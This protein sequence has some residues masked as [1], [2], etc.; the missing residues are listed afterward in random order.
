M[1]TIQAL[2]LTLFAVGTLAKCQ[3]GYECCSSCDVIYTDKD[4]NWGVEN[5]QWCGIDEE[6]CSKKS[7]AT[8]WSAAL[9]YPCCTTTTEVR[10][11]DSDGKWGFENDSW[12]GIIENNAVE[13]TCGDNCC[14]STCEVLYQDDDGDWGVEEGQWCLISKK[15]CSG[16]T[17][18]SSSSAA[19]DTTTTQAPKPTSQGITKTTLK[20]GAVLESGLFSTLPPSHTQPPYPHAENTGLASCGA[21]WT[22]VDN[23]C[24][25]MYCKDK[26]T[27]ENCDDCGG[28]A[29][30]N[31]CVSVDPSLCKSGV[32]PEVHD[33]R[34]QPWKYSRSTHFGL[35]YGG[36]CGFG[37]YG[38]CTTKYNETGDLCIKFCNNYPDLCKDP[39]NISLRGNFCAPNGNYYTQ[40]W[41][42]LP[43]DYDNYLSC[44]EC[45]EVEMTQPDGSSY[46][47]ESRPSDNILLQ[48]VDSCPCTANAKWCCGS[49]THHCNEID[50]KYG[51]PIPEGSWHV[52]LSDI[53]MSRLQTNDPYGTMVDG[54]IPIRYKRVPC[55]VKGNIHIWLR[56]GA[57][58][59]YFAL[60]VVNVAN[61]GSLVA[62]EVQ[63]ADGEW[64]PLVRDPNYSTTRPQERYGS[65]TVKQGTGPFTVPMNM[66]F[67]DSA[68]NTL[69]AQGA[70]KDWGDPKH[71]MYDFYYIDTGVQFPMPE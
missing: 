24:V 35:T 11:E 42:S 27:S 6:K 26:L 7:E 57:G 14:K 55:P 67:T 20:N 45:Y 19:T 44:G 38:L 23:V 25:A 50:F 16:S 22:M 28:V 64:V 36:A 15:V 31:G 52:D 29:R 13:D 48:V 63:Q 71:P 56:P 41:S 70:I 2:G 53:A 9:G 3:A 59:W 43:G 39:D 51:C 1:K 32:W 33:A 47:K 17:G 21:K 40:F 10:Y 18:G 66:R 69:T 4:G 8:C 46:P 54:V 34:D 65:W 68:F 62:V 30:K 58:Q 37:L 61:M 60:T 49:G 5:G 12:C